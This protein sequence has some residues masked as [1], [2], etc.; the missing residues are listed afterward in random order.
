MTCTNCGAQTFDGCLHTCPSV[1][2]Q[3]GYSNV[4][5]RVNAAQAS[6]SVH[7]DT[8]GYCL[9]CGSPVFLGITHYC[10]GPP[11]ASDSQVGGSHYTDMAIQPG[12]YAQKNG[13]GFYEGCVVKYVSRYKHKGGAE[14]LRKAMHCLE[15]ILEGLE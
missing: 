1:V 3:P 7:G 4:I 12:E 6:V 10:I 14:D 2:V 5:D 9:E 15:L 13:L 11:S 8:T